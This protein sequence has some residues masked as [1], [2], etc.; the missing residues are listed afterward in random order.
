MAGEKEISEEL[1][2]DHYS[3]QGDY[4]MHVAWSDK[5]QKWIAIITKVNTE[6]KVITM[7][8]IDNHETRVEADKWFREQIR[9]K[10]WDEEKAMPY[11]L[12][13]VKI[14]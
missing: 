4:H 14:E 11:T 7:C 13:G 5:R 3:A 6:D 2:W 10:L 8:H 12:T 9:T 1:K